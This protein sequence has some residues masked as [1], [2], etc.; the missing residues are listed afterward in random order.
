MPKVNRLLVDYIYFPRHFS[1]GPHLFLL[2]VLSIH[3]AAIGQHLRYIRINFSGSDHRPLG[4]A[5]PPCSRPPGVTKRGGRRY[6]GLSAFLLQSH[7]YRFSRNVLANVQRRRMASTPHVLQI[8]RCMFRW[9]THCRRLLHGAL[10]HWKPLPR[11][12]QAAHE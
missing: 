2:A 9:Q 4:P 10:Q 5:L 3:S 7:V 8:L 6:M 1:A 11:K 12:H